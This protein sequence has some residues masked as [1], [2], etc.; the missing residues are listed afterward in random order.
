VL[1]KWFGVRIVVERSRRIRQ[2]GP[3]SE[4]LG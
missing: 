2:I 1:M 4:E 3:D